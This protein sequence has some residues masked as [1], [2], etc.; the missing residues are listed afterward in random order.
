MKAIMGYQEVVEI[1]EEGYP[2]I[3]EGATEAQKSLYRE[4]KK[5]DCNAIVLI[6]QCVDD[7]HFEKIVGAA[8]SQEAWKILEKCNEGV[9]N[10]KKVKL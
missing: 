3:T 1:V 6:H 10:L 4:N 9:E 7:A 2:S 5:K 8:T